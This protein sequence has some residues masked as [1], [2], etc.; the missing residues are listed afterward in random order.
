[1]NVRTILRLLF[2]AVVLTGAVWFLLRG[3]DLTEVW[4]LMAQ[5]NL[6]LLALTVPLIILSHVVRAMRWK[7]LLRPA[8]PGVR[9]STAFTTVMIGYA[10]NTIVPRLGE[11][12][13]P[14]IFAQRESLTLPLAISSV[15]VE[16]V[17]DVI[18]LLISIAAVVVFAPDVVQTVMP[19]VTFE[20]LG[21]RLGVPAIGLLLLLIVVVF[22]NAGTAAVRSTVGRFS[23]PLAARLERV[24]TSVHDGMRAVREP[25][26]YVSLVVLSILVWVLYVIP[27]W[28]TAQAMPFPSAH[29]LSL[30]EATALLLVISV[31][32]TIAP[33]PGA[34]GVYQSFAQAGLMAFTSA[35]ASQ[36]L[37]FAMVAWMV[38]YGISFIVGGI[39]WMLESR[40]GIT[41]ASLRRLQH[42]S[43]TSSTPT[44]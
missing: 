36:G 8:A 21:L 2:S 22:T 33:T 14:W 27:I 7:V 11:V 24:L 41:L 18:T 1:M 42:T 40:H 6:P 28:I 26:L 38:N 3:V 19:G 39:C 25:N 15:L 37:A 32:V 10:V 20:T 31:G 12:V 4:S 5:S 17:I 30:P 44:S 29:T 16:R 43:S 23:L 9:V 13:R 34:F 35:S